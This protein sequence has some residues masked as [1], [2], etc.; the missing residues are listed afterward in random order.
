MSV[1][2]RFRLRLRIFNQ[3]KQRKERRKKTREKVFLQTNRNI[4]N[5]L[6]PDCALRVKSSKYKKYMSTFCHFRSWDSSTTTTTRRRD[7]NCDCDNDGSDCDAARWMA[8]TAQAT[9]RDNDDGWT[10]HRKDWSHWRRCSQASSSNVRG[11]SFCCATFECGIYTGENSLQ[12]KSVDQA[13][14]LY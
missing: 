8:T 6:W 2:S 1:Y 3:R 9:R 7:S 4:S 13:L 5:F 10:L 12:S 11:E 14:V